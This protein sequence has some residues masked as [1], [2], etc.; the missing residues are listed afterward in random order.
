MRGTGANADNR[1]PACAR[2]DDLGGFA[3]GRPLPCRV[4]LRSPHSPPGS[5]GQRLL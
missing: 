3:R 5:T 1:W 4:T 2:A